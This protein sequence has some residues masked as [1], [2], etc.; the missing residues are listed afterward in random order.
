MNLPVGGARERP[1]KRKRRPDCTRPGSLNRLGNPASSS[2]LLNGI[3]C[4][5][6]LRGDTVRTPEGTFTTLIY[7]Q[8][9]TVYIERRRRRILLVVDLTHGYFFFV[10]LEVEGSREGFHSAQGE[11]YRSSS[12]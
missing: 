11:M 3:I 4:L 9:R 2:L 6:Y 7:V 8:Y 12:E 10:I 1:V 5:G